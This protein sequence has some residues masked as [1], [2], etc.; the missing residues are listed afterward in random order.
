MFG[1]HRLL[2][3]CVHCCLVTRTICR[4]IQILR[5]FPQA[6]LCHGLQPLVQLL[7]SLA[8]C[9]VAEALLTF[10]AIDGVSDPVA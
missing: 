8:V 4:R 7:P 6:W 3:A 5:H 9:R 2:A 10:A 1:D